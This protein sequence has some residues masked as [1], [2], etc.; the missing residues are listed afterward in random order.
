MPTLIYH[1]K[2]LYYPCG[3]EIEVS[4]SLEIEHDTKIDGNFVYVYV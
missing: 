2:E 1:N 3:A 4:G